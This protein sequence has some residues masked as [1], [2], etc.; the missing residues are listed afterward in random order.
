MA[1]RVYALEALNLVRKVARVIPRTSAAFDL[2]PFS[3]TKVSKIAD[4]SI[5]FFKSEII[6]RRSFQEGQ[7]LL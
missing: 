1:L 3:R 2:F 6:F 4:L 7:M 5:S